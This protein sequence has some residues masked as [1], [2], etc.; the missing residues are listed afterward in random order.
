MAQVFDLGNV[1][2]TAENIQG[3]RLQNQARQQ[4]FD[5]NVLAQDVAQQQNV[6]LQQYMA[7]P[8]PEI[9]NAI[10][11]SSPE[12]AS[13]IQGLET[14][15]LA[16]TVEQQGIDKTNA[17]IAVAGATNLIN[18]AN[19]KMFAM[20]A[21]T[22]LV[23]QMR[24]NPNIDVDSLTSEDWRKV[25]NEII[26]KQ[27]IVATAGDDPEGTKFLEIMG[28]NAIYQ[29]PDGS[30]VSK[31]IVGLTES[32]LQS[33]RQVQSSKILPGGAVQITYKDG[34]T[35]VK[36]VD[37]EGL[38]I[39]KAAENRGV[40][41][42]RAMS[43]ARTTGG[44]IAERM[45]NTIT[46]GVQAVE[47]IPILRRGLELLENLETGGIDAVA[48]RAKQFFGIEGADEAELSANLGR[49]VLAKLR[50]TFGA[51]FTEKEG[52]RLEGLSAGFGKSTA[53]NKRLLRQSLVIIE[54]AAQRGLDAAIEEGDSFAR[55]QILDFQE[56]IYDLTD[57]ALSSVFNPGLQVSQMSLEELAA[58]DITKLTQEQGAAAS[59]RFKELTNG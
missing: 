29:M 59:A 36:T 1:L 5:A 12:L 15:S 33:D 43:G 54:G 18:S 17:K 32:D 46:V 55:D 56:G 58:L 7:N 35:E 42:A 14:T 49:A 41:L 30:V 27:S 20:I 13:K 11:A 4:T 23:A 40:S 26:M 39:V 2:S 8:T 53:G 38:K 57:E 24:K 48:L 37:E 22:D 52:A 51:Q 47:G 10:A 50:E 19:P 31:P 6:L 9:F 21:L 44:K 25:G 3:A 45:Q 28:G 16:Q 34:T